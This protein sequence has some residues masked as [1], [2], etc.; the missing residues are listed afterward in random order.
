MV[1][2]VRG[3]WIVMAAVLPLLPCLPGVATAQTIVG[4]LVDA[5]SGRPIQGAFLSLLAADNAIH[6]TLTSDRRGQFELKATE[7]GI[8]MISTEREA[9]ASILSDGIA[10]EA[11][12]SVS[13][14]LEVPPLSIRNMQQIG[15]TLDRNQRLR[16][17]VAELCRGRMNPVDGG[18]LLGVVRDA[19]TREPLSGA[20]AR[21]RVHVGGDPGEVS[22]AVTDPFGTYLFCFVPA[23]DRIEVVVG[24]P[25]FQTSSQEVEV[26]PG[27]I[28]W[29][30][31]RLREPVGLLLRRPDRIDMTPSGV[32][33]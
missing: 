1:G 15:E 20:V 10:L 23:G 29:Y 31:F 27:T 11:G 16:R 28:S 7:A 33:K 32:W 21:F 6:D 9:Y 26:Q 19:R 8:Y 18:I 13:Y 30:D 17:G 22:T 4:V 2:I 3:V 12:T 5:Q 25:G 24:A 14:T